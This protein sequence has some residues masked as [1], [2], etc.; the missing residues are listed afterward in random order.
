M[1]KVCKAKW[2]VFTG[3]SIKV[4][5][6]ILGKTESEYNEL[7]SRH[8]SRIVERTRRL[9]PANSESI[10]KGYKFHFEY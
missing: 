2:L 3:E 10:L 6:H 4:S 7:K 9:Y 5:V 8:W 1:E